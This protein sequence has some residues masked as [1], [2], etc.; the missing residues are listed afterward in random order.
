MSK[1]LLCEF[2]LPIDLDAF[3]ALFW[4]DGVVLDT[5]GSGGAGVG[6]LTTGS[7]YE[8]FLCEKLED[9]SVSIGEWRCSCGSPQ[10]R[11][12]SWECSCGSG[13]KTRSVRSYHPSKISFPGLPSHAESFKTHTLI[14]TQSSN[15]HTATIFECNSFRGIPYADYFT[16]NTEWTVSY[17]V[18][19]NETDLPECS[20]KVTLD[21]N[22]QKQ[23][24]L[25]GTIESNTKAELLG[26][27]EQWQNSMRQS[28]IEHERMENPILQSGRLNFNGPKDNNSVTI[29]VSAASNVNPTRLSSVFEEMDTQSS[30]ENGKD[31]I[32]R[33]GDG[34]CKDQSEFPGRKSASTLAS[35]ADSNSWR[36]MIN[37]GRTERSS[38]SLSLDYDAQSNVSEDE[39][40]FY[41]CEEGGSIGGG[42]GLSRKASI[43]RLT[44]NA[45]SLNGLSSHYIP[46]QASQELQDHYGGFNNPFPSHHQHHP[47][48]PMDEQSVSVKHPRVTTA[49]DAAV[50]V[51]ET[52]FVLAEFSFWRCHR[53]YMYEMKALFNIEASQ[54]L[55]RVTHSF[56]PGWHSPLLQLP[57]MYG[58]IIGV[59]LLPQ[60][61][62][63]SLGVGVDRHGGCSN[64]ALLGNAVVVSLCLWGG[65]SALYRILA[66]VIAPTIELKHCLCVTGYSFFA[67]SLSLLL[68]YPLDAY[69]DTIGIPVFLPLILL[70]LPSAIAQGSLF[71]EHTPSSSFVLQ[72]T[73]F[74]SSLQQCVSQ[75]SRMLQRLLWAVPKIVA[76]VLVA[77]THYQFL[78]YVARVFLPGKRQLCELAALTNPKQYADIL[79]QKELRIFLGNALKAPLSSGN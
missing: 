15:S 25:Q 3:L 24:W 50:T 9:L 26:V 67:W 55:S 1:G 35:S 74:P 59:L 65:L 75:H 29:N 12:G 48:Q 51:V 78:W 28:I 45:S 73:L 27:F 61:L 49:H 63:L 47:H 13:R 54:V 7:W 68:S 40:L 60:V 76:F 66:F 71:W 70:G 64:T 33:G 62:L 21:V 8:R 53:F 20:I 2:L 43:T 37:G 14:V 31:I 46:T 58:P 38:G 72:P 19:K 18:S 5:E 11:K 41:D 34:D 30:S 39:E 69:Q 36:D 10:A 16:V 57:D 4:L 77:G 32:I 52:F 22:F 79:S 42:G 56:V 44:R 6:V 17:Q 23:T